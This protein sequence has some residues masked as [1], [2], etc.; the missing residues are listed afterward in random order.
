MSK[1][2]EGA[3]RGSAFPAS[4]RDPAAVLAFPIDSNICRRYVFVFVPRSA[5]LRRRET[6]TL[7][8]HAF[9]GAPV[10]RIL[11]GDEVES[12]GGSE[13]HPNVKVRA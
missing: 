6:P 8:L 9:V 3:E 11:E 13:T 7:L 10:Y 1:R 2:S 4:S 5:S 12:A